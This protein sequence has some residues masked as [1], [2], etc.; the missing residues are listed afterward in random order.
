VKPDQQ[1]DG[2]EDGGFPLRVV[3]REDGSARRDLQVQRR[4]AAEIEKA[5]VGEQ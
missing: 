5:E 2:L 1:A 4:E 3:S